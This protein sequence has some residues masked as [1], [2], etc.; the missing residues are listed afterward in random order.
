V[1]DSLDEVKR[2]AGRRTFV[3]LTARD[4]VALRVSDRDDLATFPR[5]LRVSC[6]DLVSI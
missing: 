1:N 3:H 4:L 5:R 6:D 2:V